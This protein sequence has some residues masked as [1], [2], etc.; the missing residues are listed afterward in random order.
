MRG[1]AAGT[2]GSV[3]SDP[4]R[5]AVED[6]THDRLFDIEELIPRLVVERCPL[7]VA[8]AGRDRTR[9]DP[10]AKLLG[11]IQERLDF[12]EPCE[13]EVPVVQAGERPEQC[14]ALQAEEIRQRV[15]VD[16]RSVGD[17]ARICSSVEYPL[18]LGSYVFGDDC[19]ASPEIAAPSGIEIAHLLIE[20]VELMER[21]EAISRAR[22]N[23]GC[24][25]SRL[26]GLEGS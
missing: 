12:A 15:L 19:L 2:A 10:V 5:E 7:V 26:G 11:R 14:Y 3:E 13:G 21:V 23:R 18:S 16:H 22:V 24:A 6:L 25:R 4:D 1:V 17:P 9:L 20:D 8:L